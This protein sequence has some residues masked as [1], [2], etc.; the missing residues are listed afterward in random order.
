MN[1]CVTDPLCLPDN[2]FAFCKLS[3]AFH[4]FKWRIK[5]GRNRDC[6]RERGELTF[7]IRVPWLSLRGLNNQY[8]K[9]PGCALAPTTRLQ[10]PGCFLIKQNRWEAVVSAKRPGWALEYLLHFL[11]TSPDVHF[12]CKLVIF[13]NVFKR[14]NEFSAHFNSM[15]ITMF[16]GRILLWM[17]PHWV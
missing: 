3:L 14:A 5:G 7:I 6:V 10:T 8:V 16:S 4:S 12:P 17:L 11:L 15:W 1:H 9:L 13:I 2:R